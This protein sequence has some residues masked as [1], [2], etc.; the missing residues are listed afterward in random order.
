[1]GNNT[2]VRFTIQEFLA[3]EL[4]LIRSRKKGGDVEMS[5]T[6]EELNERKFNVKKWI[7]ESLLRRFGMCS[8]FR[9][10]GE[11]TREEILEGLKE[12]NRTAGDY[13]KTKLPKAIH[14]L[15]RLRFLQEEQW[16]NELRKFNGANFE[17]A[18]KQNIER[19]KIQEGHEQAREILLE[20]FSQK[21]ISEGTRKIIKYGL[22][23]LNSDE[24]KNNEKRFELKIYAYIDIEKFKKKILED[25]QWD[26]NYYKER[27]VKEKK[28]A[29]EALKAFQQV[30]RDV[31]EFFGPSEE[32]EIV[33][34]NGERKL[35]KRG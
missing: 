17:Y 14:E 7:E 10:S 16:K 6:I 3:F 1:M 28:E 8:I 33:K 34:K 19:R 9:D 24:T 20:F 5:I 11:M 25:A 29:K 2:N 31:E 21:A 4:L 26:V 30:L 27:L 12:N 15:E 13:Y 22:E 18:D 35:T 32:T 23:Q